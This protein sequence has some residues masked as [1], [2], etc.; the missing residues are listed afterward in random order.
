MIKEG[1]VKIRDLAE[2]EPMR[3]EN[4]MNMK[5]APQS[6]SLVRFV[7]FHQAVL[8]LAHTTKFLFYSM[9]TYLRVTCH[10][11]GSDDISDPT[12]VSIETLQS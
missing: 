1:L 6:F 12:K 11:K 7:S 3:K 2:F 4:E 10:P 5:K 8:C 9:L